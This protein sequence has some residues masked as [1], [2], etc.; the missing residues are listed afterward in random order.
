M[1]IYVVYILFQFIEGDTFMAPYHS[2]QD[3]PNGWYRGLSRD[4]KG[5]VQVRYPGQIGLQYNIVTI[6]QYG[7]VCYDAYAKTQKNEY[8]ETFFAQV[9]YIMDGGEELELING[10]ARYRALFPVPERNLPAG[11]VGAM[12]QGLVTSLLLRAHHLTGDNSYLQR[13]GESIR[14]MV[15]YIEDGGARTHSPLFDF[16]VE[17]YPTEIP[18]RFKWIHFW[19]PW[20]AGIYQLYKRHISPFKLG[21]PSTTKGYASL[22]Y[23]ML[24]NV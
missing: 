14:C 12:G 6:A 18:S 13:A 9:E 7:I 8:R 20:V 10:V 5:V 24:D 19:I 15:K 17:E 3:G 2:F 11:T 23:R 22:R 16:W 1:G 21:N 4:A